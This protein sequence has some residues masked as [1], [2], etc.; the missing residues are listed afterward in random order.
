MLENADTY[1]RHTEKDTNANE[2]ADKDTYAESYSKEQKR[3][4]YLIHRYSRVYSRHSYS[5]VYSRCRYS[6]VYSRY[7]YRYI[8]PTQA[9]ID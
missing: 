6:R 5:R 3:F 8:E 2:N 4:G 9:S 7:S 1:G